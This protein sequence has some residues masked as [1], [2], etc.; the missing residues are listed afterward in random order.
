MDLISK[1]LVIICN[2]FFIFVK[3]LLFKSVTG[4]NFLCD[5]FPLRK[6][7]TSLTQL[8]YNGEIVSIS[9]GGLYIL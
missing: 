4:F 7:E 8:D 6:R 9:K 1:K 3:S 5:N 2:Y